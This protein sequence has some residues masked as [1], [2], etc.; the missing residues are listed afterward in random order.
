MKEKKPQKGPEGRG[1]HTMP[2]RLK[3]QAILI[4]EDPYISL[5]TLSF[6]RFKHLYRFE[7]WRCRKKTSR[8]CEA[9]I[10]PQIIKGE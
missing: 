3:R 2:S 8:R 10:C 5:V 7:K 6:N 9:Q 4:L 1:S